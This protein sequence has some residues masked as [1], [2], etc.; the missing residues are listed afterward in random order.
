MNYR[1][2]YI[3]RLKG[4]AILLVVIGHLMA[5]CTHGERNPIYEVICSFHM[6][7][8]MFL[9]GLVLTYTPPHYTARYLGKKALR[10]LLPM[11]WIGLLFTYTNGKDWMAFIADRYKQGYWYL[12]ILTLFYLLMYVYGKLPKVKRSW[13]LDLAYLAF[14]Q[15]TFMVVDRM[16]GEKLSDMTGCSLCRGYWMF[17]LGFMARRYGWAEWLSEHNWLFTLALVTYI[18][19]LYAY[20]TGIFVRFGQLLPL[21]TF[22]ILV[23]VFRQREHS[24]CKVEEVLAAVGRSTLDIYVLHY[25]ILRVVS[26]TDAA[27]YLHHSSNYLLELVMLIAMA[28]IVSGVCITVG[29][30]LRQSDIIRIIVYGDL[31]KR[32]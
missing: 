32:K 16:F 29:K 23:F 30:V 10:F 19:L 25:F 7:L 3:D 5:F 22:I 2:Q 24:V 27:T 20:E 28:L 31:I 4:L 1:I 17:F 6:P 9:S 11:L 8:F 13:L 18:P 26:L 15:I 12:Y 21:S 14:W